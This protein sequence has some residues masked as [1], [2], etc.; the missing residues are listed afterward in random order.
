MNF[1][2]YLS[3]Y[4]FIKSYSVDSFDDIKKVESNI[5]KDKYW[6]KY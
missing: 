3:P 6:G 1:R 2:Q 5:V 4:K